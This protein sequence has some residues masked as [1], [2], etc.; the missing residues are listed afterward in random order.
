MS[1]NYIV[2]V[3]ESGD[4]N[5]TKVNPS[6]PMFVL[7]FCVFEKTVYAEKLV[8]S[9]IKM[10]FKHFGHDM[11]ILHERD[12]RKQTGAFSGMLHQDLFLN[13]LTNIIDGVDV[14]I[15]A[16]VIDKNALKSKYAYPYEPY[17]LAM[18]YGLERLW[19]FL[20]AH[21][22]ADDQITYVVCEA[23]GKKE[24]SDLELAFR[25]ICSGQNRNKKNYPFEVKIVSKLTNSNGL[26]LADLTARP[27]GLYVLRPEQANRTYAILAKKF[28]RGAS[29][30]TEIGNG[31]KIFPS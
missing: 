26:Q 30:A 4:P 5:L 22:V 9:M 16:V 6:F 8:P 31:L 11:V 24:D 10:K 25:R 20:R 21:Q 19:D 1:S 15:I 29:G 13:E 27:I 2:Y 23:R 14:T 17:T 12:I 7:S 18:T 3:D 28:W